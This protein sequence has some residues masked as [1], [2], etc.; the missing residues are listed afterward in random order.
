[1]SPNRLYLM[2]EANVSVFI[3]WFWV[4][5]WLKLDMTWLSKSLRLCHEQDFSWS[6]LAL[7]EKVQLKLDYILRWGGS[8]ETC[9]IVP[10]NEWRNPLLSSLSDP[11]QW[12]EC[13]RFP[14]KIKSKRQIVIRNVDFKCYWH[15]FFFILLVRVSHFRLTYQYISDNCRPT[16]RK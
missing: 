11:V 1:M 16:A 3:I 4:S 8:V 5:R 6:W 13:W 12:V 14:C 9:I 7:G 15:H 10:W 2:Q